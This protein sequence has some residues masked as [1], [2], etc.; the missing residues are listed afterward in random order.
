M[1]K[2]SFNPTPA[3][4]ASTNQSV[5]ATTASTEFAMGANV[6]LI[7]CANQAVTILFGA[8]GSVTAPTAST[9][10]LIPANTFFAFTTPRNTPSFKVFNTSG[11]TALVTVQRVQ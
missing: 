6:S 5:N 7:L 11:S 9:G 10:F 3:Q 8:A 4:E 1:A 2:L